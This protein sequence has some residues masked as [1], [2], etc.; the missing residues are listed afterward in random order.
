VKHNTFYLIP[1]VLLAL[2]AIPAVAEDTNIIMPMDGKASAQSYQGLGT[3][4]S[5]DVKAGKI[6]L[7]HGPIPSLGWKAMTMNF[8]VQDKA[9]LANLKKGQKVTFNLIEVRKGRY[10]ISEITMAK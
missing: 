4:N 9:L 2:T 1:L 6:N 8:E 5:V 7:S 10:V 3:I